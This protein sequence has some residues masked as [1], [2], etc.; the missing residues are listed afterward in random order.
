MSQLLAQ[1]QQDGAT[2]VVGPLLKDN[3]EEVIK[4]NTRST[5]WRSTS[6]RKSKAAPIFAIS[7]FAG[8]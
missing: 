8:R 5:C 3:V 7:P 2:I 4:S 6:R 1:V